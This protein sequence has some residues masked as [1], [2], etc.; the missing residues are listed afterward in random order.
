MGEQGA[1][2]G[3]ESHLSTHRRQDSTAEEPLPTETVPETRAPT[4]QSEQ[5]DQIMQEFSRVSRELVTDGGE[6]TASTPAAETAPRLSRNSSTSSHRQNGDYFTAHRDRRPSP[7]SR[8]SSVPIAPKPLEPPVTRA[9]LSELDVSKIIHNPKLRHDINFDPELHFRPNLDGEKGKRKQEKAN[10]FWN[11]LMEQLV[12]FVMDREG[13]YARYGTDDNWCLP[14]L[15]KAARE[16]I[17]TLVPQRDRDLLNDGLNVELLMQQFHRGVA[18]LEKLAAWLSGVLKLHCAPM[19]D[20]WVDEMYNELSNG[21]RNNDMGELVKGMRNLLSVLEAMKLDVANH[22]IRCLRPVLIEDTVHFE[23]RFFIKK[24]SAGKLSI[25]SA[26]QWYRT[27][28]AA[29]SIAYA[30]TPS[31]HA[32][33]FGE[34]GTFFEALTHLVLPST[35]TAAV[36]NTFL[37]DEERILKLR[38]DMYDSICLEICMR[39]Y[40]DYESLSR[41]FSGVPAYLSEDNG[42]TLSTRSSAEFNFSRPSSLTFSDRNSLSSTASSPRSS[43]IFTPNTGACTPAPHDSAESRRKAQELYSSLLALLHTA[44]PASRPD[45][46]WKNLAGAMALQ[47]L[48]F[49]NHP[50]ASLAELEANLVR[51]LGDPTCE[52]FREVEAEFQQKLLGEV[53]VKVKEFRNLSGVG[54]FSRATGGRIQTPGTRAWNA[55]GAGDHL[56]TPG[57][58]KVMG[59]QSLGG[60]EPSTNASSSS[61]SSNRDP[62]EEAGVEDMATRVAHFG[63]LHWRVWAQLAYVGDDSE[64]GGEL[65]SQLEARQSE[66]AEHFAAAANVGCR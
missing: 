28:T 34:T 11:M 65:M 39:K 58:S 42:R 15:L 53:A 30:N 59:I 8:S 54:L 20:E 25:D 55:G 2:G 9:T 17:E 6:S 44:P 18:D 43:I 45:Y 38:S 31:P 24:I 60:S 14:A 35:S 26:K 3:F 10:Q 61:S 64:Y 41:Q 56:R 46:R 1:G 32:Q 7:L 19:R 57:A 52:V 16:I 33:A 62:R 4:Q 47:I 27:A 23:Q 22:Q 66:Y 51:V 12:Q 36:P 37:F 49:V 50:Q 21:N 29:A 48:R 40:E 5:E 63:I 13:F